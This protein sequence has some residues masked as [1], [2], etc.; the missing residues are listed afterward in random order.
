MDNNEIAWV[1]GLLE[2]EGCFSLTKAKN[3]MYISCS[4]TDKDII[5]KLYSL[6]KYGTVIKDKLRPNRKQVYTWR[7]SNRREI[8]I[9]TSLIKPFMG[10]RRTEK[11]NLMLEHNK[12]HPKLRQEKGM[13]K[14]GTRSMYS[15]YGCRCEDCRQAERLY[16][17]PD[18]PRQ[19]HRRKNV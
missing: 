16:K 15:T 10:A 11:I 5:E 4:M 7:M 2:G 14:H 6:I 18:A 17:R 1:A 8:D 12:L 3:R 19:Y 9:F 13:V